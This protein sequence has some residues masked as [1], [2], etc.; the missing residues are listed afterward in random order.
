ML[1]ANAVATL[2]NQVQLIG[3]FRIVE[4]RVKGHRAQLKPVDEDDARVRG[5][6]QCLRVYAGSVR[7]RD[8][9]ATRGVCGG[10]NGERMAGLRI[11][12]TFTLY[13]EI[14]ADPRS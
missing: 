6:S 3:P 12:R 5:V 10:H 7:R 8:I 4:D 9:F 14:S 2:T 11:V 1:D 13:H